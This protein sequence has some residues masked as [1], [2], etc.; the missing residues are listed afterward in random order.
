MFN[1]LALAVLICRIYTVQQEIAVA[2][3]WPAE[4]IPPG[5]PS[6]PAPGGNRSRPGG[7]GGRKV[8]FPARG[9]PSLTG[10]ARLVDAHPRRLGEE[11][12]TT[13]KHSKV[14]RPGKGR[15][16]PGGLF[17]AVFRWGSVFIR[18]ISFSSVRYDHFR[19][20]SVR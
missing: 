2:G 6:R 7:P 17:R 10:S 20:G 18:L 12:A 8:A 19:L 4:K 11:K 16:Q 5:R 13:A 9:T 3:R 15:Q 14:R 1:D